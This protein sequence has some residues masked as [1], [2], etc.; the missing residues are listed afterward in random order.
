[1]LL[2]QRMHLEPRLKTEETPHLRLGQGTRPITLRGNGFQS[3]TG[4]VAPLPCEGFRDVF[5][6]A[7]RD[8]HGTLHLTIAMA[9]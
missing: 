3:M 4:H 9:G 6:Q 2:Q 1:M 7:D 5:R 8:I